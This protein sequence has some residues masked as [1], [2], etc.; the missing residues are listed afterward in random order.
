[1]LLESIL[2]EDGLHNTKAVTDSQCVAFE[3][4]NF[5]PDIVL[6]D[7]RMP[8]LDGF[9]IMRMIR[10]RDGQEDFLPI[11]V[12]TA[13]VELE[14]RRRALAEGAN[15]FL[16]K[17]F[18]QLEVLLRTRS[19][20]RT[21]FL[22]CDL[23]RQNS[24]L[25]KKVRDRTEALKLAHVEVIERLAKA[26]EA[27]DDDTGDHTK[28][29]GAMSGWIA[30]ALGM[31]D[32]EVEMIRL[33]AQLHDIGK[34]AIPHSILAKPGKLT[35]EEYEDMKKHARIG[36]EILAES[37]APILKLAEEIALTHHERW[38]GTGYPNGLAG[39]EI[40][41][42][43]RIVAVTDVF[44]ALSHTRPY[45]KAWPVSKCVQEIQ[46]LSGLQFDPRVV[47]AMVKV[48]SEAGVLK[49]DS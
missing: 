10:Q 46:R 15:D 25:E 43:G 36:A 26:C 33:A 16:T 37:D 23:Q 4:D 9:D 8:I 35:Q 2:H 24:Q 30:S 3:L 44:D 48:L 18:D 12:L 13:D 38:D 49:Y 29:V 27:H 42:S 34:T 19:L 40:P 7:L 32:R 28:R 17:P 11:L 5:A 41:L 6:L 39:E 47:D 20:L 31:P 21:R 14:T 1:M 22:H 45:K